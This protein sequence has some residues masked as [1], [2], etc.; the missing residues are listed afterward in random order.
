MI[1][2]PHHLLTTS[3]SRVA[4]GHITAQGNGLYVGNNM[5]GGALLLENGFASHFPDPQSLLNTANVKPVPKQIP[6]SVA[7]IP[8]PKGSGLF[9][10]GTLADFTKKLRK[11]ADEPVANSKKRG[12]I[13]FQ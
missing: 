4:L 2:L 5:S 11:M 12:N 1:L 6:P 13:C 9:V 3:N 7:T 8:K 10:G